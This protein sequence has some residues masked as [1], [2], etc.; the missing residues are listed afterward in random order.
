M[1]IRTILTIFSSHIIVVKTSSKRLR[2]IHSTVVHQ[3]EFLLAHMNYARLVAPL[4]DP[5]MAEFAL[6]M[7]PVNRIAK[8][9]P[10]FVWSLDD[11]SDEQR[12]EVK[13]LRDDPLLMP[14]LSMW[15][16]VDAIHHFAFKSGHAMYL[17][18]RKE[19]FTSPEPPYSVCWWRLWSGDDDDVP[20]L[21]EAFDKLLYLKQHGPSVIAFDFKTAKEYPKPQLD[22]VD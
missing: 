19:W 2:Q 9:T 20:T 7:D 6:A 22:D 5:S 8:S 11:I 1:S 3:H 10:G 4:D 21:K 14:Q 13:E 15:K 18:R 16:S 17:K 12:N